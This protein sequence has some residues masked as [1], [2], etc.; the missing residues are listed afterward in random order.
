MSKKLILGIS[1]G[2][3][4][5]ALVAIGFSATAG[6]ASDVAAPVSTPD[7]N[8]V[9]YHVV[10]T[11]M[12]P[13][14]QDGDWLLARESKLAVGR[15]DIII[16]RYPKDET[17]VYCRRVIGTQGDKVVTKYYSNVKLT[18]VFSSAHPGGVAFPS[19]VTPLGQAY[20]EY[21]ATVGAGQYYVVGDN[22]VPGGSFDS[23]E[24]G[25]LPAGDVAGKVISRANPS[26]RVF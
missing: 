8:T 18:T 10:G 17:K 7:T 4:G 20:G 12:D 16:L 13:T 19:G 22:A 11:S 26:P 24:W 23:D 5:L 1:A 6:H 15:G 21:E 2:V 3:V 25:L 9:R 14:I